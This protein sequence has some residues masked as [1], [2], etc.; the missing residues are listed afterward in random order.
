MNHATLSGNTNLLMKGPE[1]IVYACSTKRSEPLEP[2]K[3][4]WDAA[5]ICDDHPEIRRAAILLFSVSGGQTNK[6]CW[7]TDEYQK[8]QS[9][10]C[11]TNFTMGNVWAASACSQREGVHVAICQP[12]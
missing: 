10:A 12:D 4:T 8:Q 5:A 11:D 1:D 6:R 3:F 2:R 9:A 7:Q